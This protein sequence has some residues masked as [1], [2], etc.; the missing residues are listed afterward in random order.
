MPSKTADV[1]LLLA[2]DLPGVG[3]LVKRLVVIPLDGYL[4]LAEVTEKFLTCLLRFLL[5]TVCLEDQGTRDAAAE[6]HIFGKEPVSH[7]LGTEG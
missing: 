3:L 2:E 5:S 7:R 4:V 6:L 1:G